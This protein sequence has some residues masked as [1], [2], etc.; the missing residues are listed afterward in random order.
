MTNFLLFKY[1]ER[2][3]FLYNKKRNNLELKCKTFLK[4]SF[5]TVLYK[6]LFFCFPSDT[7]KVHGGSSKCVACEDKTTT[8]GKTGATVCKGKHRH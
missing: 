7:Y 2:V 4:F 6:K 5:E 8:D 1:Q 3:W